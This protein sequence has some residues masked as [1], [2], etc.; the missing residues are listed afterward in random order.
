MKKDEQ[1]KI[2]NEVI[3]KFTEFCDDGNR[4]GDPIRLNHCRAYVGEKQ[5]YYFLI[6]YKT[7]VAFIDKNTH[8]CYDMLRFTYGYTS[9]SAQHIAKFC[10][11]YGA[12]DTLTYRPVK[13]V[14]H[15]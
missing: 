8:I 13:G 11:A 4:I 5:N 7:M 9:T 1:Y 12:V 2:N 15:D 14:S 3:L 10:R 6:S